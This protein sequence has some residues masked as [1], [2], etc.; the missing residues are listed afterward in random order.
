MSIEWSDEQLKA[1]DIP[2][3]KLA[4]LVRKLIECSEAMRELG[5]NVYG[6][7]GSGYL[8]HESRPEH[9]RQGK[10]DM[11]AIVATIGGG[12]DGGGW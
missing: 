8:I 4:A 3:R 5:L 7:D 11:G 10:A 6:S 9:N 1:V 2:K 12:F